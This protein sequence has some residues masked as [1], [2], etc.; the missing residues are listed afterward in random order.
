[1]Q[2]TR[3]ATDMPTQAETARGVP[4]QQPPCATLSMT[5]PAAMPVQR[6]APT[7]RQQLCAE[8]APRCEPTPCWEA[9]L[10]RNGA[11]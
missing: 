3:C 10:P 6:A 11:Q 7:D 2:A 4:G 9:G 8:S 1:M 5:Q